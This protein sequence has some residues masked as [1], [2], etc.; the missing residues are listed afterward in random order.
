M[1]IGKRRLVSLPYLTVPYRIV[2]NGNLPYVT[3]RTLPG[4]EYSST[5]LGSQNLKEKKKPEYL[6]DKTKPKR[7]QPVPLWW[8]AVKLYSQNAKILTSTSLMRGIELHPRRLK[9]EGV[10]TTT[11]RDC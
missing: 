6:S 7:R 8:A 10:A 9:H 3:I 5:V 4:Y 11:E 2:S 1:T